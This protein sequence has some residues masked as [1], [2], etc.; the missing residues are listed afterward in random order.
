MTGFA[1]SKT[2]AVDQGTAVM[3]PFPDLHLI[4]I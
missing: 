3:R 1:A 4:E 2:Y